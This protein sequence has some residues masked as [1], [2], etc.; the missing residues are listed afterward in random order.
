MSEKKVRI[1]KHNKVAARDR[2]EWEKIKVKR[3][4]IEVQEDEVYVKKPFIIREQIA[5]HPVRIQI[6]S[7]SDLDCIS[8]RFVK[9]HN[10]PTRKHPNPVRIRGFNRDLVEEVDRQTKVPLMLG[11]VE[12]ERIKLDLVTTDVDTI[13]GV[14]WLKRNRPQ[15]RWRNN[16]LR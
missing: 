9:R 10:L 2:K 6:D 5:G 11:E 4:H 15:F 16:T 12:V 1:F 7:G 14:G 13:L 3:N 8:K